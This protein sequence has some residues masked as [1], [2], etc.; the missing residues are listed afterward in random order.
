MIDDLEHRS[1]DRI[2]KNFGDLKDEDFN[3][4]MQVIEKMHRILEV[5]EKVTR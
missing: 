3:L 4:V 2:Q 5:S 1:Y